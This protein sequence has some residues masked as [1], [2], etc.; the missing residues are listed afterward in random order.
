VR[1]VVAVKHVPDVL[2]TRGLG[3]DGR[4]D[5]DRGDGALNELDENAVEAA[6]QLAAGS[7][8]EIVAISVGP[9]DAIDAVRRA[10]QLGAHRG[11]LVSDPRLA[12]LDA[13]A[14]AA[15]LAA[16]VALEA[17]VDLVLTGMSSTDGMTGV[18]PTALAVRLGIPALPLA[19]EVTLADGRVRVRR[20]LDHA[21]E[22][23]SAPLPA[24]VSVTDSANEPSFPGFRAIMAA[25]KKQ[26]RTV[27]LDDLAPQLRGLGLG[28]DDLAPRTRV[29]AAAPRPARTGQVL[30]R[31]DGD[32]GTRLAAWLVDRHLA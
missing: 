20:E 23:V 13:P 28:L 14:T 11:V 12:G 4:L 9:I 24:L 16:A 15:V 2:S 7:S 31:D 25:R 29:L 5:R 8:A 27:G 22:V 32:A 6:V 17:P 30:D 19:T 21:T 3:P 18:V 1:I 10:L 26:V